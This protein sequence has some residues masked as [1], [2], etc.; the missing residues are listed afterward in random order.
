MMI[1]YK[2]IKFG[3]FV[4]KG[5]VSNGISRFMQKDYRRGWR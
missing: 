1:L 2:L 5:G 3:L 4:L